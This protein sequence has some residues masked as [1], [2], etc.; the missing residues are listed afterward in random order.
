MTRMQ[1]ALF[2]HS[3]D[4]VII[5]NQHMLH[6]YKNVNLIPVLVYTAETATRLTRVIKLRSQS[7]CEDTIMA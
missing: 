5:T 2:G 6:S 4:N 7:P 3:Y 1:Q